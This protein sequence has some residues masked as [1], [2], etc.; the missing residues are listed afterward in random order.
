[1]LYILSVKWLSGCSQVGNH[2]MY[3]KWVQVTPF[4]GISLDPLL[5]LLG[6]PP[7]NFFFFFLDGNFKL[8]P[9]MKVCFVLRDVLTKTPKIIMRKRGKGHFGPNFGP[10][11]TILDKSWVTVIVKILKLKVAL[12]EQVI[13]WNNVF[14]FIQK[15][16][17]IQKLLLIL[18]EVYFY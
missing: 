17:G 1:M 12:F 4:Y 3:Q 10:L 11:L 15:S 6:A 2:E 18:W 13:H 14:Y 5:M 9:I 8:W 16:Y 7:C